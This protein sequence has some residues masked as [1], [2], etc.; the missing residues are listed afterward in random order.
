MNKNDSYDIVVE[1]F[2]NAM[3]VV[4]DNK[5][6]YGFGYTA[7]LVANALSIALLTS[8]DGKALVDAYAASQLSFQNNSSSFIGAGVGLI[9][10]GATIVGLVSSYRNYKETHEVGV[11]LKKAFK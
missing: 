3:Q 8:Y 2:D 5:L 4:E 10:V 11:A 1:D 9:G 6:K 7:C